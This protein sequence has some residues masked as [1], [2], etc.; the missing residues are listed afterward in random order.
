[1]VLQGLE[2][3]VERLLVAVAGLADRDARLGRD[4][5][6]AA[7][8]PELVAAV[9]EDA[10][11]SDLRGQD[12]RVVVR[13]H[14]PERPELDVLRAGGALAPE[15]EWVRGDRE[16]REEE[17]LDDAVGVVSEPVRVDD[18]LDDLVIETLR[19]L[20][21]PVL[22]FQ[23]ER[24]P[25]LHLLRMSDFDRISIGCQSRSVRL[26][27][28]RAA[29]ASA[30]LPRFSRSNSWATIV[31]EPAPRPGPGCVLAPMCQRP[32]TG[33]RWPGSEGRG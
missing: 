2:E 26:P 13:Q 14:V 11:S 24:E 3:D 17:M 21:A 8:R 1:L 27:R 7:E 16:L 12:G 18:L 15:R 32:A 23:V 31:P 20:P 25:H 6:V 19:R 10:G 4:P 28:C 22:D 5:A 9:E 30:R 29:K 33:V